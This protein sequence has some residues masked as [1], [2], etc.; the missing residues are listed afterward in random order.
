MRSSAEK[1]QSN[2]Y[3]IIMNVEPAVTINKSQTIQLDYGTLLFVNVPKG[4]DIIVTIPE[5]DIETAMS[6]ARG[7]TNRI[8]GIFSFL[9]KSS[10]PELQIMKAYNVTP[11]KTSGEFIQYFYDLPFSASSAR[12]I[13]REH[14][15]ESSK[16]ISTLDKVDNNRVLRAMHWFRLAIKSKDVL[17]RF[18]SLWIGL[19]TINLT[20][21]KH[22]NLEIEYSICECGR[23][24]AP[25][26]NG[27]KRLFDEINGGKSNWRKIT[28]LRAGTIHGFQP[29]HVIVPQ[30]KEKIP[31]LE[32]ALHQG[33]ALILGM[34]FTDDLIV[35]IAKSHNIH[36]QSTAKIHGP[37]LQLIDRTI[38]PSFEYRIGIF[39]PESGGRWLRF[40]TTSVIDEN[41]EFRDE[42]HILKAQPH[43]AN[44]I[45]IDM[46]EEKR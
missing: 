17:E 11:G 15:K 31:I 25:K 18:T 42:E 19:E 14:L 6:I 13:G 7:L 38:A 23:K 39:Y 28:K 29:L 1:K 41:F 3:R 10:I 44:Q 27:V 5:S 9:A 8:L 30:L 26:L 43:L 22:Y 32:Q 33:L 12:E 21:C 40:A 46:I 35:D 2:V 20:L 4:L 37:N 45:R 16:A 24:K 36:Y 34:E